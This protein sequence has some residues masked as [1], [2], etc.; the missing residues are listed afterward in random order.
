MAETVAQSKE[1]K[2]ARKREKQAQRLE[3]AKA[4]W[5]NRY[6]HHIDNGS[7]LGREIAAG[8]LVCILSVCGI[9]MNLQLVSALLV[10]GPSASAS[11]ADI[12]A[13][14]EIIC[15]MYFFAMMTAFV[16]S[17]VMGLVARLPL[18]QIPSMGMTVVLIELDSL[19]GRLWMVGSEDAQ[20]LHLS[21]LLNNMEFGKVFK[22][23]F[24]FTAFTEAGGN[25]AALFATAI[26]TFLFMN[27]NFLETA[28][29]ENGKK[30]Q[31]AMVC[32]AGI[33]VLAPIVGSAPVSVTPLNG[34][35]K[36]DGGRSGIA[37][38]VASIGFLISAFVW[39]IPFLFCTTTN[40]DITFNLY[41]HYGTVIQMMTENTSF[42]VVDGV[43]VL[44]GL[45]L[46]AVSIKDGFA[47][48]GELTVYLATILG[49]FLLMN[50]AFGMAM[51]TVAHLLVS[52][53]DRERKLTIGNVAAAV[54]SIG[55]VI[56]TLL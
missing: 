31:L 17:L 41:G 29:A 38:V 37:A 16:G 8:I 30:M 13:N 9:F 3:K 1:E 2:K 47:A 4:G 56:L 25:V 12:A 6:F 45:Y 44:V 54:L 15:R 51:G 27:L 46:V 11:V 28:V 19:W 40:Y 49:G 18:A 24:D 33:N 20:H 36:R 42:L 14:G 43:M 5:L 32:N 21:Y 39:L 35:G 22:E 52:L 7:T 50:P 48:D 53:F 10:S 23:G 55:L 26:L 34:A